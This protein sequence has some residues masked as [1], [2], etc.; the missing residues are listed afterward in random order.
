VGNVQGGGGG[1]RNRCV[2]ARLLDVKQRTR[3]DKRTAT[4]TVQSSPAESL[5]EMFFF[6][7]AK[8]SKNENNFEGEGEEEGG[9]LKMKRKRLCIAQS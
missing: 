4:K 1:R 3:Q 5:Q 9:T 6:L 7:G 2:K 8:N